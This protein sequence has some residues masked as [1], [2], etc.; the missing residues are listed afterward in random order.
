MDNKSKLESIEKSFFEKINSDKTIAIIKKEIRNELDENIKNEIGDA[1]HEFNKT[2]L[3]LLRRLK[4]LLE[5]ETESLSVY[6]CYTALAVSIMALFL[7]IPTNQVGML[8]SI[9][10]SALLCLFLLL[11][12]YK[13]NKESKNRLFLKLILEELIMELDENSKQ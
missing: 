8:I 11:K 7:S 10:I 2:E 5:D 1:N 9:T 3:K 13:V 4:A 12:I 6:I